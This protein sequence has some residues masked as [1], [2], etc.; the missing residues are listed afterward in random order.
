MYTGISASSLR[1]QGKI[2]EAL[3]IHGKTLAIYDCALG[4]S[5]TRRVLVLE[6]ATEHR[7]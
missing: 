3:E 5:T 7:W 4:M 2:A 6:S 1:N